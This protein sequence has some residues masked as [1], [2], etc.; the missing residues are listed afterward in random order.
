MVIYTGSSDVFL[1]KGIHQYVLVYSTRGHVG[2]FDDY[3]ELYW[4]VNGNGWKF[5]IDHVSATLRLPDGAEAIQWSC[6]TGEQGSTAKD[7]RCNDNTS[8]PTFTANLPLKP[9]EGLT[10][11]VAF[12]RDIIQRPPPPTR[13]ET[14]WANHGNMILA[15]IV[16]LI[17]AASQRFMWYKWGRSAKKQTV[18]PQFSPPNGWSAAKVRMLFKRKFDNKTFTVALLQAAVKGGL[19]IEC[20]QEKNKPKYHLIPGKREK[21]N[22]NE[23]EM[24]DS[25]FVPPTGDSEAPQEI[26]ISGKDKYVLAAGMSSVKKVTSLN[27]WNLENKVQ[28][29]ISIILCVVLCITF[30]CIADLDA[31]DS[32]FPIILATLLPIVFHQIFRFSMKGMS[33]TGARE[34]AELDGLKMYL[35]T[36]EKHWLNQLMPPQKTP[37]HFEEMLPYAIALNVENQWGEKFHDVLKNYLPQWYENEGLSKDDERYLFRADTFNALDSSLLATGAYFSAK[38]SSYSSG[39]SSSSG[40]SKWSS[41]S[42]GGGYSGGGGGGGG[43]GGW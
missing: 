39:G 33:E 25:L 13:A 18:I 2:F 43:G 6:Y 38:Y 23:K 34:K 24:F 35:G 17:I 7:C 28:R 9:A 37:E 29:W 4:N 5:T 40:S 36:A 20:R 42:D 21:L 16:L 32:G 8:A 22:S 14:F 27:K 15:L 11:A 1:E 19:K 10:V 31:D 30:C 3:D 12:P 26:E 41:G